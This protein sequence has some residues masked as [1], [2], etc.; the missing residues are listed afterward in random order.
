M[1]WDGLSIGLAERLR[2]G[3]MPEERGL[4]P[5]MP[6]GEQLGYFGELHGLDG[7]A[8]RAAAADWLNRLDL[9]GRADA[10]LEELSHG[11]QQRVQLAAALLHRPEL[12]VLDEPFAGLDPV[13]VQTLTDVLRGEAARGAAVL[14]SSHQLDL[15]EDICE[16]VAIIDHGRIIATGELDSLRRASHQRRIELQLEGAQRPGCR[17]SAAS[18]WSSAETATYACSQAKTSIRSGCSRR[19]SGPDASSRSATAHRRSP[20]SSWSWWRDERA[21]RDH[22][23]RPPRDPRTP[24][25]QAASS[26][27]P[28][29]MVLLVAG[30]AALQ[31]TL[32]KQPTYHV[33]VIA[34]SP[35]GLLAALQRAAKPFDDAKVQ[36]RV[37]ATPAAGRQAARSQQGRRP[38]APV[39]ATGSSS[40]RSRHQ[41]AA[42]ADTAVRALRHHLPPAPELAA[43]TLHAAGQAKTT[44]AE[45]LV[46]Y[47]RLAPAAHVARRLRAMGP[48]R[49]RRREEQPRRRGDP[50][51]PCGRAT[52]SPAR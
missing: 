43:A 32:S 14:F 24:A 29:L 33:A 38:P 42:V 40:A 30:S 19:P 21:P 45:T 49:R 22:P 23:R 17:A 39:A 20:S 47:A 6:V 5:R 18:S 13:A 46:A 8:A 1:L 27:R 34:P 4:Y 51:R 3:Y 12:L 52:C 50:R 16:D 11:N 35:P 26:S 2:F 36:L 37:V 48:D 10:K 9:A 41:A 44:D 31:G 25:R 7:E 28:S 15:V